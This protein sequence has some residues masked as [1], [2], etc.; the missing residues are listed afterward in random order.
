MYFLRVIVGETYESTL[1]INV[2]RLVTFFFQGIY[3]DI[4]DNTRTIAI[5][6]HD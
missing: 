6:N 4:K 5:Q 2:I 3:Y 1:N